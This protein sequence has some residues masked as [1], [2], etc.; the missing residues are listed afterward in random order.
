MEPP[1]SYRYDVIQPDQIRLCRFMQE[2][3]KISAILKTVSTDESLP[4]YTALSYTWS[5][6]DE[7]PAK[8]HSIQI[9]EQRLPTL[10]SLESFLRVLA[11]R[12]TLLNQTWWWIDSICIDQSNDVERASH[13]RRMKEIYEGASDVIVWLG[14]RSDDSDSAVDFMHL[15]HDMSGPDGDES[16]DALRQHDKHQSQW[17]A[18]RNFFS[19]RWWTRIWTIQ[20]FVVPSHV[21]LWCDMRSI[22]RTAICGALWVADRGNITGFKDTIAFH[23]AWNRRRAWALRTALITPG[24]F[25][26][27]LLSLAAYFCSNEATNDRDRLY[28]LLAIAT[29]RHGLEVNY[30]WTVDE[31]Y[32]KFAQSFIK[33]HQSLDIICFASLFRAAVGSS[34]PSWVPDW[35]HRVVPLVVPL[36]V[37]QSS[38]TEIGNLR[39]PRTME[40][41]GKTVLYS[42]CM[43]RKAEYNFEG[44]ALYARGIII[45]AV[46][47]LVGAQN[48]DLVQSSVEP[49]SMPNADMTR[50]SMD[51]LMAVC[52]SLTWGSM[53]RYLRYAMPVEEFYRDFYH[54]CLLA[55]RSSD[56]VSKEFCQWFDHVGSLRIQGRSLEN[57]ICD[58]QQSSTGPAI[59]YAPEQNEYIQDSFYGRF[60]DTVERMS[61]RLMISSGSRLGMAPRGAMKGDL[62]CILFGCSVPVLLRKTQDEEH[63]TLV[64]ECFLDGCMRG[65]MMSQSGPME[66]TFR[67]V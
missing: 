58:A 67:I 12:P 51:I 20:E 6:G 30:S 18:L 37:S 46:D 50:S 26:P 59:G 40:Y 2:N 17:V 42:A 56:S 65:E 62:V 1:A 52:R 34:L 54:L 32:L 44:S 57:L 61:L 43:A 64:G 11:A 49:P 47:G 19:R 15:L 45:D 13:V 22:S 48:L 31:V 66:R 14:E 23:H 29:E 7:S 4:D 16:R 21:S 33:L 28:G 63:F 10:D 55:A 8:N 36:M 5:L 3:D 9:G 27:S 60:V 25:D 39:P 41:A 53:D 38:K 24:G 35:R